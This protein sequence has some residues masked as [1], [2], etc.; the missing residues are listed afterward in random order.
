MRRRSQSV[1]SGDELETNG[2]LSVT[3]EISEIFIILA[4]VYVTLWIINK[5][6]T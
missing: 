3:R 4:L 5:V 2:M 6:R 1:I